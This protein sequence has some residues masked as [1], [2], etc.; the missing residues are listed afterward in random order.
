MG[1]ARS[2]MQAALASVSTRT[3][4]PSIPGHGTGSLVREKTRCSRRWPAATTTSC[5][6]PSARGCD[7]G[8]RRSFPSLGSR[9]P[10]SAP[11][12]RNLARLWRGPSL[13]PP[14]CR[15]FRRATGTFDDSSDPGPHPPLAGYVAAH[16]GHAGT[17]GSRL[18][19]RRVLWLFAFSRF[20]HDLG[21]CLCLFAEPESRR[22]A[23]GYLLEP[24]LDH[25][26]LLRVRNHDGG[27]RHGSPAATRAGNASQ[28]AL[29][30][31]AVG[32]P[33]LARAGR[34]PQAAS[35]AVY[36]GLP[37][38]RSDAGGAVLPAGAG[39]RHQPEAHSR[40]H[41]QTALNT[42]LLHRIS[43]NQISDLDYR[44]CHR[45]IWLKFQVLPL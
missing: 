36:R 3:R 18:C 16:P 40:H 42:S 13:E 23:A 26:A 20:A 1:C 30:A 37:H 31:V 24:A 39:V 14:K 4:C 2:R 43:T 17:D 32:R 10:A 44:F 41:A 11:A 15:R 38:W 34:N 45:K 22:G 5:C 19:P 9:S 6:L 25:R 28:F 27:T 33:V 21:R 12:Q 29:R 8:S 7:A 35:L